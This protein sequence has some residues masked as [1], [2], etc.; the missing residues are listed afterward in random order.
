[1]TSFSDPCPQIVIAGKA[2]S[3]IGNP[4]VFREF[5]VGFSTQSLYVC[6]DKED[7]KNIY[8]NLFRIYDPHWDRQKV[9]HIAEIDPNLTV[10]PKT[11]LRIGKLGPPKNGHNTR[12]DHISPTEDHK[13]RTECITTITTLIWVV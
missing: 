8:Y 6:W 9:D 12:K 5:R 2:I 4:V 10:Y 13:T 11:L 3:D 1:M 7:H